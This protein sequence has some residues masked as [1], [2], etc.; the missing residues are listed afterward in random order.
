MTEIELL[1]SI[2]DLLLSLVPLANLLTGIIQFGIVV[3]AIVI[4][5]KLFNLFF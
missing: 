1:Q 2:Y 4:L 5:Y 3:F